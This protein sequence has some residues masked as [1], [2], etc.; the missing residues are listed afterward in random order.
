MLDQEDQV[1]FKEI[2]QVFR[3]FFGT[4]IKLTALLNQIQEERNLNA[5]MK[6][7]I[8]LAVEVK[9]RKYSQK[10]NSLSLQNKYLLNQRNKKE[11]EKILFFNKTYCYL[12]I[13]II[14]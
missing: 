4:S 6:N 1:V 13:I 11:E 12:Y 14:P 3:L 2:I 9:R 5:K 8:N 10:K 7:L